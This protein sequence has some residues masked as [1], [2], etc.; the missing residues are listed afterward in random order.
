MGNM[1]VWP[2]V[3][4]ANTPRPTVGGLLAFVAVALGLSALRVV[5]DLATGFGVGTLPVPAGILIGIVWGLWHLP[6]F[7]PTSGTIHSDLEFWPFLLLIGAYSGVLGL[8][9]NAAGGNVLPVALSHLLF[10]VSTQL[11]L[12]GV[13]HQP[14]MLFVVA[15]GLFALMIGLVSWRERRSQNV[16]FGLFDQARP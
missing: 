13:G 11:S 8:L 1:T 5:T 15:A 4:G 7:L 16:W 12:A 14:Q 2:E 9:F 6:L 10:N 3:T